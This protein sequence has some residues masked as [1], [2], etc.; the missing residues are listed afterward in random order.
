MARKMLNI[1]DL[2]KKMCKYVTHL[3]GTL[4]VSKQN[5]GFK[6]ELP[7][8]ITEKGCPWHLMMPMKL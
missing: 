5:D 7:W 2:N 3:Q 4:F 8:F 1:Y 6:V